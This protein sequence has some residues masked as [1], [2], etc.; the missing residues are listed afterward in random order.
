MKRKGKNAAL[1]IANAKE[2]ILTIARCTIFFLFLN[3]KE[4]LENG[5][6]NY[7]KRQII[8]LPKYTSEN[9]IRKRKTVFGISSQPL[10]TSQHSQKPDPEQEFY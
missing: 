7:F 2:K 5:E 3:E 6:I 10:L 1:V 8:N 4:G 9:E